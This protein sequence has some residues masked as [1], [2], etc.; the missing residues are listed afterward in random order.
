MSYKKV[1]GTRRLLFGGYVME[2]EIREIHVCMYA[3]MYIYMYVH[4][5]KKGGG[6]MM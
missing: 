2:K 6:A 1:D 3:C 4:V 5:S